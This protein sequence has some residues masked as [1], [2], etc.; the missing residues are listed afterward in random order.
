MNSRFREKTHVLMVVSRGSL[1][2][3]FLCNDGHVAIHDR[4]SQKIRIINLVLMW[5]RFIS[6][7]KLF[8]NKH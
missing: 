7:I 5:S 2:G 6:E 1:L 3:E 4:K 8:T